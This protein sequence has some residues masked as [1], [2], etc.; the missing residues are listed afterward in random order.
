MMGGLSG[1]RGLIPLQKLGFTCIIHQMNEIIFLYLS[2]YSILR[3]NVKIENSTWKPYFVY[4]Y[5]SNVHISTNYALDGLSFI[6]M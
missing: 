5:F 6:C 1:K 4:F 2:M 3:I